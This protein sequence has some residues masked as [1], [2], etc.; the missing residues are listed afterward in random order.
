MIT[1]SQLDSHLRGMSERMQTTLDQH[2]DTEAGLRALLRQ[3][4]HATTIDE[5]DLVESVPAVAARKP[6][7]RLAMFRAWF[8]VFAALSLY[9]VWVIGVEYRVRLH[10]PAFVLPNLGVLLAWWGVFVKTCVAWSRV[11]AEAVP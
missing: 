5:Q 6:V 3:A 1:D 2:A 9:L 10:E 11:R 7:S 8:V 4:E